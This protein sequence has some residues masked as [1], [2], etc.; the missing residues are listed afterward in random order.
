M[1]TVRK[2][3][4]TPTGGPN[5]KPKLAVIISECGEL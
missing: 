2:I 3:E 4:N 1:M 5:A